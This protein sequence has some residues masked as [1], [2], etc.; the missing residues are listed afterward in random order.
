MLSHTTMNSCSFTS[1]ITFLKTSDLN[2]LASFKSLTHWLMVVEGAS[3]MSQHLFRLIMTLT[4]AYNKLDMKLFTFTQHSITNNK[5]K[6]VLIRMT[7]F[8]MMA[9]CQDQHKNTEQL[10]IRLVVWFQHCE[11]NKFSVLQ[12]ILLM[13]R[14]SF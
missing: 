1:I 8:L 5:S 6:N 12:D 7:I 13:L 2:T 11:L 9:W 10:F 4:Y 14:A 3:D